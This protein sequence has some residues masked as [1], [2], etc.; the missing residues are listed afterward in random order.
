MNK[1]KKTK[2]SKGETCSF[3]FYTTFTKI[4]KKRS[5]DVLKFYYYYNKAKSEITDD[6]K[7][8]IT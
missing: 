5:V 2:Y 6:L 4:L 8:F 1:K 3:I 7:Y